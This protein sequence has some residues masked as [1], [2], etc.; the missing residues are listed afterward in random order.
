MF[1][2]GVPSQVSVL[3]GTQLISVCLDVLIPFFFFSGILKH[4]DNFK[5]SLQKS[6][7]FLPAIIQ[8]NICQGR[9]I[10]LGR[11]SGFL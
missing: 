5:Q 11:H 6:E 8:S 4:H 7:H 3:S 9:K 1:F 10:L 2:H